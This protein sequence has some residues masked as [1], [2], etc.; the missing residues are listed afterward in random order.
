MIRQPGEYLVASLLLRTE[1]AGEVKPEVALHRSQ[2]LGV[3]AR[4]RGFPGSLSAS[5][6][7]AEVKAAL[8]SLLGAWPSKDLEVPSWSFGVNAIFVAPAVLRKRGLFHVGRDGDLSLYFGYWNP[9]A[10]SD[11][12][13]AQVALRDVFAEELR[14]LLGTQFTDKQLCRFP[15]IK[16]Q[17]WIEKAPELISMIKRIITPTTGA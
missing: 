4:R 2:R 3:Q 8:R 17:Q 9:D 13:P 14:Q 12:G 1:Q 6:L 15:T 10:Y 5:A 16:A 7:S 11:V